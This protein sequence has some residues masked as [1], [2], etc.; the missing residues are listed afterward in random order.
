MEVY[1]V[2][3]NEAGSDCYGTQIL[4]PIGRD[5]EILPRNPHHFVCQGYD[6]ERNA[7]NEAAPAIDE[8]LII[9]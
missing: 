6:P 9:Q 1:T 2:L 5:G 8:S 3:S 4:S 7:F